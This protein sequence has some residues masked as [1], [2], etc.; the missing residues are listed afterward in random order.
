VFSSVTTSLAQLDL[1][2]RAPRESQNLEFKQATKQYD[3]GKLLRYCVAIANE[4]GGTLILGVTDAL[5][6]VVVGTAAFPDPGGIQ[7]WILVK[8]GMRVA[9]EEIQ[10]AAGRVLLFHIPGRLRGSAYELDG[11]YLMRSGEDTVPMTEDRLRAIFGE[12]RPDWLAE[13]A[14]PR[15]SV[16]DVVQL[17]DTQGF[18]DLLKLPYPDRREAVLERLVREHLIAP[19]G[20]DFDILNLGA[21]LFAKHLDDFSEVARKAPRVI[22]YDGTSKAKTRREQTGSRGYAVAFEGLVQFVES[23][24]PANEVIGQALRTEMRMYPS[25]MLRETMANAL[26]HQDFRATGVSVMIEVYDDRV[27]ISNPGQPGVQVERLIDE[28][29]SRNEQ[30]ADLMRRIGVCEEKGSGIDKVV[31]AAE[32]YQLPAPEFRV[33]NVRTTCILYGQRP[34]SDMTRDDRVRA[35]YQHCCLRYVLRDTTTNQSLRMRFGLTNKRAETVSRIL[36]DA[37]DAG[38]VRSENPDGSRKYARYL[39]FWA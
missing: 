4:G 39:P 27:E 12:G 35:C 10:H 37:I 7:S 20:P 22:V 23:Q 17:L 9:A 30:L 1:W 34:F 14:R 33:D 26:I 15:A 8:L 25:I 18:F 19:S 38:L 2:L 11:A 29:Q 13:V 36:R 21:I 28:Y 3:S 31:I 6:R 16:A 24:T 32:A 5:P